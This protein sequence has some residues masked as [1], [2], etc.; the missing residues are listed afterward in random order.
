LLAHQLT[1]QHEEIKSLRAANI[2]L[3]KR[4]RAKRT[5]I[6][7]GG[8]LTVEEATDLITRREA[9]KLAERDLQE[10]GEVDRGVQPALRLCSNCRR[11]G[12]DRRTCQELLLVL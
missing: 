6:Q 9:V 5:Q 4:K 2:A 3:S 8:P 1:L 12:H 10:Q 7:A 11:P